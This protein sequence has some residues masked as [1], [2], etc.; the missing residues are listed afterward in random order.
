[1][2]EKSTAS[3]L[4]GHYPVILKMCQSPLKHNVMTCKIKYTCKKINM[5]NSVK[6]IQYIVPY[7]WGFCVRV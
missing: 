1:M 2:T 7:Y 3:L 6:W 4:P 5:Q